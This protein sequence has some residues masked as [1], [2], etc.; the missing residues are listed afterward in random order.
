MGGV[1]SRAHVYSSL[2]VLLYINQLARLLRVLLC[3]CKL[4][5]KVLDLPQS[6]SHILLS[7]H[8]LGLSHLKVLHHLVFRW[9]FQLGRWCLAVH[10]SVFR[11]RISL[12]DVVV[13]EGLHY[14]VIDGCDRSSFQLASVIADVDRLHGFSHGGDLGFKVLDNCCIVRH[15]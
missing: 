6:L 5:N 9:R 15:A 11:T 14:S 4:L 12:H 7:R 10:S 3:E 8:H 2:E 13:A 1:D